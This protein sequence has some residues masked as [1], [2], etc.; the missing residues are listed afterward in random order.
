MTKWDRFN[1]SLGRLGADLSF[2]D[3]HIY[4][5]AETYDSTTGESSWSKTEHSNSPVSGEWVEPQEPTTVQDA[6]GSE[7]TVDVRVRIPDDTGIPIVTAGV[8]GERMTTIEDSE[9]GKPVVVWSVHDE[10]NGL[11]KLH[12]V[13]E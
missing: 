10:N 8:D 2:R 9:T 13:S 11:L 5:W 1:S 12:G 3:L 4:E 6:S 7:A